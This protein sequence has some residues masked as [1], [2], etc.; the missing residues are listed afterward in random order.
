VVCTNRNAIWNTHALTQSGS[1]RDP[2]FNCH[3]Q[4]SWQQKGFLFLWQC[5]TFIGFTHP[6]KQSIKQE[7]VSTSI[8]FHV[9]KSLNLPQHYQAP[10]HKTRSFDPLLTTE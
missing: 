1:K 8:I 9:S 4:S 7:D 10:L 5:S 2:S 6:T 3:E